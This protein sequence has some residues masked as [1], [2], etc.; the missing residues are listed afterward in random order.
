MKEKTCEN[1]TCE[2][3]GKDFKCEVSTGKCWCFEIKL[4]TEKIDKIKQT[5]ENCLCKDCLENI[6][7]ELHK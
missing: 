1:L 7:Y 5:Y 6:S 3:C 2:S 4:D